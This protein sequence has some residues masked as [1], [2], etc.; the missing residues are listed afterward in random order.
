[1]R[2]FG[3]A[4]GFGARKWSNHIEGKEVKKQVPLFLSLFDAMEESDSWWVRLFRNEARISLVQWR[5]ST[6][7]AAVVSR[8]P[9]LT[10]FGGVDFVKLL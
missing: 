6:L 7:T 10:S 5:A 4:D 9:G 8:S 1:M 2:G 3:D